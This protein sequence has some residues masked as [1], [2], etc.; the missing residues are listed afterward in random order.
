[1]NHATSKSTVINSSSVTLENMKTELNDMIY[2]MIELAWEGIDLVEQIKENLEMNKSISLTNTTPQI[3]PL[4]NHRKVLN[5]QCL[6]LLSR[7]PPPSPL[8]RT[9]LLDHQKSL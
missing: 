8:L 9:T 4:S 7:H 6:P 3:R 1:M 5:C 2:A